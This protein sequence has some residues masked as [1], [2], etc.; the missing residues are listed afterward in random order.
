MTNRSFENTIEFARMLDVQDPLKNFR[1][2]FIIPETGNKKQI[3][4]LGNSLGLQPKATKTE[5]QKVLD[6]WSQYGV[7]AFFMGDEP[8]LDYH[9]KL[10]KQ[11]VRHLDLQASDDRLYHC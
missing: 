10:K 8:W 9:D 3:Y 4:F 11:H 5:L 6:Q 1:D 2:K 7:E